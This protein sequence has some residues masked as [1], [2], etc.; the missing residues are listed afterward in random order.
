MK[1]Y[2]AIVQDKDADLLGG[3]IVLHEGIEAVRPLYE[4]HSGQWVNIV[5]M[6][7]PVVLAKYQPAHF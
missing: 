4:K 3:Y 2:V 6:D 7:G 5:V 1:S